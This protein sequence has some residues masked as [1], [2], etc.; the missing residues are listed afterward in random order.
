[1]SAPKNPPAFPLHPGAFFPGAQY[2]P[3][4]ERHRLWAGM[5]L[6]DWFAGKALAGQLANPRWPNADGVLPASEEDCA[7]HW[8]YSFA[9][10]MLKERDR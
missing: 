9:D 3:D 2:L 10:A 1:M 5:T 8:A 4:D 7:A 6:R